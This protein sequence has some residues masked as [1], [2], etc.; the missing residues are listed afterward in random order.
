MLAIEQQP[1]HKNK[2]FISIAAVLVGFVMTVAIIRGFS[3]DSEQAATPS[4][5]TST[6]SP[7]SST[8]SDRRSP[9]TGKK[10]T[11]DQA[12][13]SDDQPAAATTLT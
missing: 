12:V 10:D 1:L 9:V 7:E 2:L 8:A 11:D 5:D 3:D 4:S 6:S 13:G